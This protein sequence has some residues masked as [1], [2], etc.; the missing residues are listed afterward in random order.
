[1]TTLVTGAG[2]IGTLT[3]R[4]LAG[5]G[6]K[7]VLFD[8]A[9]QR[10]AIAATLRPHD[11][12]VVAGDVASFAALAAAVETHRV[13]RIVH[14]AAMLTAAI[15]ADPPRGIGV[16]ILGAVNVLE[17]ARR[18]GLARV[19]LA[20]S[21]TVG[22]PAFNSNPGERYPE[23]FRMKVLSER[24]TT[25]Y[26]ATKLAGEHLALIYAADFGVDVVLLR[27]GAVIGEWAG[28]NRSIPGR[29]VRALLVPAMKGETAVIDDP[30]LVWQGGDDFVDARDCAR[31]NRAALEA[32]APRQ[33]VYYVTFGRM[34]S[35]DDFVAATR[36]LYPNFRID[37]R[38][39]AKAGFAGFPAVRPATSD[40]RAA[41][42]ELGFS[43]QYDLRAAL[44][45]CAR[46]LAP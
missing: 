10:E 7:V 9:P 46:L 16:N 12:P 27:Y 41:E 24:P 37:L 20:S 39:T 13:C 11:I 4:H 32:Q 40:L 21:S 36:G 45:E 34:H 17:A 19:V 15:K 35:F 2:L 31:A 1:M 3:A 25:F 38:V 26:S 18:F 14:T 30:M 6:Q 29:L 42:C 23:D 22:Y 8:V 5:Q 44:A 33:R 43:P 28:A